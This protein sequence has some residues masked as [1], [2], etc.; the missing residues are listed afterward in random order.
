M[1]A[2]Y[3]LLRDHEDASIVHVLPPAPRLATTADGAPA[4]SLVQYL[5]G[6]AR[7]DRLAGG[8]LSLTTKLEVSDADLSVLAERLR[9]RPGDEASG[10][11]RLQ[12][13]AFD[14]GTVELVVLGARSAVPGET[15]AAENASAFDIAFSGTGQPSLGGANTATFQ[16]LLDAQ[17]AELIERC[18]DAPEVPVIVIYRMGFSGL[19]PS[20][21]VSVDADWEKVYRSLENRASANVWYVAA[22][23]EVMV[24]E[25]LEDSGVRIDTTVFG[26]GEEA[27]AAAERA[28]THLVEWVL[29]RLFTPLADP[30]AAMANAVGDVVDDTVWSLTRSVM[31]GV[32]YRLRAVDEAQLRMLSARMDESTAE[33]REIVPQATLGGLLHPHRTTTDGAPDPGWTDVRAGLVTKVD[34]DG[35]PRLEVG[36]GVEDRFALDGL[37]EVRVH[38]DR[39]APDGTGTDAR[40]FAFRRAQ[41]RHDYVVNLLGEGPVDFANPYRYRVEAVFDPTGPF[42]PHAPVLSAWQRGRA[43]DLVVEPRLAYTVADVDVTAAPLFSFAQFPMIT[44][45][46]RGVVDGAPALGSSRVQLS[47]DQPMARWRFRSFEPGTPGYEYRATYHR[48]RAAGGD[49]SLGWR[50]TYDPWLSLPDPMPDKRPLNVFVD[51]PWAD[52]RLAFLQLRYRDEANGIAF[53]DHIDLDP[54]APVVR[55]E[56]AIADGGPRTIS[57]R[58]TM[59]LASGA[60]VE[61]SWLPTEDDRLV[62]DGRSV[63]KRLIRI[64]AIGGTLADHGLREAKVHLEVRE[65]GTDHIRAQHEAR[66]AAPEEQPPAPFEYLLGDPPA[67]EVAFRGVFVST[68]GFVT[69]SPWASTT[70]DLLVVNLRTRTVSG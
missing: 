52:V 39:E 70:A 51:L 5:G 69:Q 35:F 43:T 29:D 58:L 31:P 1:V 22:D 17:A 4:L 61:G 3:T 50:R 54:A 53:D 2:G 67:K 24:S 42:G 18:L 23:A 6:G 12:P 66:I 40:S 32:A 30:A 60:L 33:R 19:R 37:S 68:N 49:V 15:G 41:D 62:V 20:F 36:V 25:A 9:G 10:E 57:Y 59:L 44:V 28:R 55:R 48:D 34:I 8:I 14:S 46:L 38:L 27:R 64:E 11:F 26:T 13:V 65:P 56:Y 45:E 63:E 21:S 16:V 47:A 7:A